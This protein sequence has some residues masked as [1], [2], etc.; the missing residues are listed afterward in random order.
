MR[1]GAGLPVAVVG[2]G[3]IRVR[4]AVRPQLRGHDRR[5]LP[6]LPRLA[7]TTGIDEDRIEAAWLGTCVGSLI[8]QETVTGRGAGRAPAVLPPPGQPGRERVL[9]GQRRRPQRRH[10][11]RRRRLRRRPR[12][13]R[14]EDAR[15]PVAR[16]ADPPD[17]RDVPRVVEAARRHGPEP[18][19]SVR[20]RRTWTPTAPRESTSPSIAEKNHHNGSL[21]PNAFFRREVTCEQVLNAPLVSWPLGLL[22]CCPTTDG[23]AAVILARADLAHA[24]HRP[25]ALLAGHR[26]G[27]RPADQQLEAELHVVP[28]HGRGGGAGVHDGRHRARATSTSPRC[29]T[30]SR[31]PSS[32]PT[33]TSASA[34]A[35]SGGQ[36]AGVG[37]ARCWAATSPSTPAAG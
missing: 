30:A 31:S 37:R 8:R 18:V 21:N 27:D 29:T 28:G 10:G 22:D 33:R 35:A 1:P 7:S 25:P 23:A 20:A 26:A 4:R 17:R 24:V 2:A 14:R 9:H 32:S 13:R 11:R 6:R 16:L 34:S 5:R 19:R 12:R 36:V 15:R 3:M